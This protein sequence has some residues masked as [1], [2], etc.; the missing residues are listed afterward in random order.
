MLKW[1]NLPENQREK[2]T[3]E[4]LQ[5]LDRVVLVK[6]TEAEGM[7]VMVTVA[8]KIEMTPNVLADLY[9]AKQ[10]TP[11]EMAEIVIQQIL[12]SMNATLMPLLEH[13][14]GK[15]LKEPPFKKGLL[16]VVKT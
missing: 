7:E 8:A 6:A 3:A 1:P 11:P 9:A 5:A 4:L 12:I 10:R 13:H 15:A 14:I 2:V 16:E